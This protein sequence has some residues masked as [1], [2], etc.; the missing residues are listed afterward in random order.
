M[1]AT[2]LPSSALSKLMTITEGDI[3]KNRIDM[4]SLKLFP[5]FVVLAAMVILLGP[6]LARAQSSNTIYGC[7]DKTN[8][9]LRRVNSAADCAKSET[10]ISWNVQGPQGPQGPQGAKGDTGTQGPQGPKG[11]TGAQGQ[12][13]TKGDKG[14]LGSTGPQGL[15]GAKGDAGAQGPK[16]DRGDAGQSVT[17]FTIPAGTDCPTGGVMYT[18]A[19][20]NHFV[21]NGAKGLKGDTGA[22]GPQGPL[23]IGLSGLFGDGSDGDVTIS[24]A[25]T[26]TRDVYYRN[27]TINAGQT[28]NPGGFRIFVSDT[29]TLAEGTSINRN[30]NPG[31]A[32]NGGARLIG[33]TLGEG[34]AGG[35]PDA[36]GD[37]EVNSLGGSGGFGGGTRPTGGAAPPPVLSAGGDG[38]FH[39]A[40]Q[41]LSGRSLDGTI[42]RGG[43][44]GAGGAIGNGGGGGGGGVVVVAARNI[45]LSGPTGSVNP[46]IT[47][48]GGDAF[49]GVAGGGGGGGGVVIVI[50][51]TNIIFLN[52]RVS[53]IG[54]GGSGGGG[55]GEPGF[56]AWWN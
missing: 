23:G 26:Q 4:K 16:G 38:V 32:S 40:I 33:G 53:A 20:G 55:I 29:L 56:R 10:L 11:D 14:D 50:T 41:A 47:A 27:L 3:M 30:G 21:C 49:G 22:Q 15:Q 2:I 45:V 19:D 31:T 28:L 24:A 34:A 51:T 13:G 37:P 44:G 6:T 35:G 5:A 1:E 12:T 39:S 36:F 8:G 7:Y 48:D 18:S 54:G 25:T 43:G 46:R 9:N 42:V 17:G 52:L